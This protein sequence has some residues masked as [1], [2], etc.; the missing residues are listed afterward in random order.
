MYIPPDDIVITLPTADERSIG[1]S[2]LVEEER[3]EHLAR[4]GRLVPGTRDDPLG[5]QG[6]GIVDEHVDT[7]LVREDRVGKRPDLIEL[8]EI[9]TRNA[10]PARSGRGGDLVGDALRLTG[11][12]PT[13]TTRAPSRANC[14]AASRP[15]PEVA[16]VTT[17]VRPSRS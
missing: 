3:P 12:R 5:A 8:T 17:T 14:A 7:L 16:P 6:T 1:R 10:E 15:I 9:R 4:D 13:T 11:L 2:R